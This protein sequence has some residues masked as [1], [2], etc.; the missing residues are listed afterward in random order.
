MNYPKGLVRVIARG[1][2]R[3]W[4]CEGRIRHVTRGGAAPSLHEVWNYYGQGL[5]LRI[6]KSVYR[7]VKV[8]RLCVEK[9]AGGFAVVPVTR[10]VRIEKISP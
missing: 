8:D 7:P 2:D 9:E 10:A 6:F 4:S 1:G 5:S 3:A